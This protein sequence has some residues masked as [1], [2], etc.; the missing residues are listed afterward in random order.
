LRF[1]DDFWIAL[2][3]R[4]PKMVADRHDRMPVGA[5]V[6]ARLKTPAQNGMDSNRVKVVC[7]GDASSHDLGA[8]AN[9]QSRAGDG[10]DK[11]GPTKGA[12]CLHVEQI[13]PRR[14][15]SLLT[16]RSGQCDK[17]LLVSNERIRPQE[18]AF[19]PAEH[20]GVGADAERKAQNH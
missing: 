12:A 13:G 11:N 18:K 19:D 15:V 20:G 1:A 10:T 4:L 6:F 8:L 9:A 5:G 3:A 16:H 2:E 14:L 17:L 7:G